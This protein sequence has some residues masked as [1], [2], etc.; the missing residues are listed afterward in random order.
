MAWSCKISWP[1][2]WNMPMVIKFTTNHKW[3][4]ITELIHLLN[5]TYPHPGV[6]ISVENHLYQEDT[7]MLR[8]LSNSFENMFPFNVFADKTQ[9]ASSLCRPTQIAPLSQ[10]AGASTGRCK[11][12]LLGCDLP[13]K[14]LEAQALGLK[15]KSLNDINVTSHWSIY[16]Y[17][18]IYIYTW[19]VAFDRCQMIMILP[20]LLA[21]TSCWTNSRLPVVWDALRYWISVTDVMAPT[22]TALGFL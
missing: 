4:K 17:I 5:T 22:W 8:K 14:A 21:W 20:L 10:V 15:H 11:R 7:Y 19:L 18:Y 6:H 2:F 3:A 1:S 12:F 13:R 9:V 16:I